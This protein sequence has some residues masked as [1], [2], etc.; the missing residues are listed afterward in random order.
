[1]ALRIIIGD[2]ALHVA[3]RRRDKAMFKYLLDYGFDPKRRNKNRQTV[4]DVCKDQPELL[5]L[6]KD[7]FFS[8]QVGD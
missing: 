4:K 3:A 2:T 7:K 8:E 6:L 1:M 5:D